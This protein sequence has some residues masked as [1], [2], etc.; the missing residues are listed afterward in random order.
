MPESASDDPAGGGDPVTPSP[1]GFRVGSQPPS[2][3]DEGAHDGRELGA[4]AGDAAPAEG[5]PAGE[6]A[7]DLGAELDPLSRVPVRAE[8]HLLVVGGNP[9]AGA[10]DVVEPFKA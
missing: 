1:A 6:V 7:A 9:G 8:R 2:E 4:V 10:A 5:R 3:L